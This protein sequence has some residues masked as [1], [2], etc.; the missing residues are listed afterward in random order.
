MSEFQ[1]ARLVLMEQHVELFYVADFYVPASSGRRSASVMNMDLYG[2]GPRTRR[3]R[4]VD[5]D[6]GTRVEADFGYRPK[7]TRLELEEAC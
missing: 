2:L 7:L 6:S 5:A 3:W 4:R 1:A